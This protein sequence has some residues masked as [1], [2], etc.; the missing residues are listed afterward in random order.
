MKIPIVLEELEWC[1]VLGALLN[2]IESFRKNTGYEAE[3]LKAIHEKV[4][5]QVQDTHNSVLPQ[6]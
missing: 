3:G 2:D 4:S 5:Q 1:A 6:S